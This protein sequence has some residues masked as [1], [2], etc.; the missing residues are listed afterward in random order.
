MGIIG[1]YYRWIRL[2]AFSAFVSRGGRRTHGSR[3]GE[4][5]SRKGE[6]FGMYMEL[7]YG[8]AGYVLEGLF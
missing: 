6:C 4:K 2:L 3:E 8:G 5:K 7:I 1:Y